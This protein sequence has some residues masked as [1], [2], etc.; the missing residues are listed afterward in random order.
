M[1]NCNRHEVFERSDD[2]DNDTTNNN[3]NTSELT[4]FE[5]NNEPILILIKD[6]ICSTK[7]I[8]NGYNQGFI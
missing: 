1:N 5:N 8:T 3:N 7:R 2:I 6:L 4:E